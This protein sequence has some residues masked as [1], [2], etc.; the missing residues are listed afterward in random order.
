M[1]CAAKSAQLPHQSAAAAGQHLG[2]AEKAHSA[3]PARRRFGFRA[4]HNSSSIH[5]VQLPT[6]SGGDYG[7]FLRAQTD[8]GQRRGGREVL[9][10]FQSGSLDKILEQFPMPENLCLLPRSFCRMTYLL[11]VRGGKGGRGGTIGTMSSC[12][13]TYNL[14]PPRHLL[15]LPSMASIF[16]FV[17]SYVSPAILSDPEST[18]A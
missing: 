9:V 1:S 2:T 15:P 18:L 13:C 3:P 14:T 4:L 8:Q 6:V 17:S 16:L 5:T 11:R 7:D 10:Y 12:L